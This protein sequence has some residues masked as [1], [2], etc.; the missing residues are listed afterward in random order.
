MSSTLLIFAYAQG[1]FFCF[2][3]KK[4]QTY[5]W[6]IQYNEF[7]CAIH[8]PSPKDNILHNRSFK[9]LH[10]SIYL[11]QQI[12]EKG[13]KIIQ[14]WNGSFHEMGLRQ[15]NIHMKKN[16]VRPISQTQHKN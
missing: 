16:E 13:T 8:P 14:W 4:F 1:H 9:N 11:C 5:K 6:Q 10:Q 2:F 15:S 3:L 12:L 7:P